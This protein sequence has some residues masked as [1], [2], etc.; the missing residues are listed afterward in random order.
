MQYRT[1]LISF[2]FFIFVLGAGL[3]A[4]VPNPPPTQSVEQTICTPTSSQPTPGNIYKAIPQTWANTIYEY[5]A[6][7][8]PFNNS[9][10]DQQ[11]I[12]ARYAA[13]N[14]LID[15]TKRWSAY[16][17]IALGNGNEARITITLIG[18][19]LVQAI[20]LNEILEHKMFTSD[21]AS[22]LQ[23]GLDSISARDEF[24]FLVSV[25]ATQYD[26]SASSSNLTTI[27]LPMNDMALIN[28]AG[29]KVYHKHDDNNLEQTIYLSYGPAYGYVAYPMAIK[30]NE[31]CSWVLDSKYNTSIVLNVPGVLVNGQDRGPRSWVIHYAS[32]IDPGVP[33]PS[34]LFIIP[35]DFNK[36][37]ISPLIDPPIPVA[38]NSVTDD[39]W[40][41][42]ARFLWEHVALANHP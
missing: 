20:Y 21:F 42:M 5:A 31:N 38:N 22:Q 35:P 1:K 17:T 9:S 7:P 12:E 11:I 29:V 33:P 41:D 8:T 18:P 15:E 28:A 32:L 39:Y 25:S 19:E 10:Q 13:L 4:C 16:Q 2:A 3:P 26:Y 34:P 27:T 23:K 37:L 24:V 14:Y 6:T 30:V 40:R 36:D